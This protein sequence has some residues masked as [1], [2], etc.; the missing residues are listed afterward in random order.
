MGWWIGENAAFTGQASAINSYQEVSA[1]FEIKLSG[2]TARFCVTQDGRLLGII[3]PNRP[4]DASVWISCACAHVQARAANGAKDSALM[5][6]GDAWTLHLARAHRVYRRLTKGGSAVKAGAKVAAFAAADILILPSGGRRSSEVEGRIQMNQTPAFVEAIT[7][8]SHVRSRFDFVKPDGPPL[9]QGYRWI[10]EPGLGGVYRLER[11]GSLRR[12]PRLVDRECREANSLPRSTQSAGRHPR[13]WSGSASASKMETSQSSGGRNSLSAASSIRSGW[14]GLA[15]TW[16]MSCGSTRLF[17]TCGPVSRGEPVLD[18][19]EQVL[20]EYRAPRVR[21]SVPSS[22]EQA[23]SGPETDIGRTGAT[24]MF[25]TNQRLIVVAARS[26]DA[27]TAGKPWWVSHFR[28]EW[29]YEVGTSPRR[30]GRSP[31][32]P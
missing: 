13:W 25:I 19:G 3:S 32:S 4:S 21:V 12:P 26:R 2:A 24:R 27:G 5:I 6:G 11:S 8:A 29:I 7:N 20:H 14:T 1:P 16:T 31:C 23:D 30:A 9:G 22:A 18:A 15:R 17:G 10:A 28:H